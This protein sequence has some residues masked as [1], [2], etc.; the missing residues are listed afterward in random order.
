[1]FNVVNG[2]PT[3]YI[4]LYGYDMADIA[5]FVADA[6]SRCGKKVIVCDVTAEKTLYSCFKGSE[7]EMSPALVGNVLYC[8]GFNDE[9]ADVKI[10]CAGFSGLYEYRDCLNF[11]VAGYSGAKMMEVKHF[12][13]CIAGFDLVVRGEKPSTGPDVNIVSCI[14]T[15]GGLRINNIFEIGNNNDAAIKA[16]FFGIMDYRAITREYMNMLE[17]T[18]R[19]CGIDEVTIRKVVRGDYGI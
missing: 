9:W 11:L 12:A 10:I 3:K 13:D 2:M 4:V 16:E 14:D 6:M 19:E 15:V 1:M 17:Y 18:A 7:G 8:C 5:L